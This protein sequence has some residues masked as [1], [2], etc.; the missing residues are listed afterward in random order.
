MDRIII[1]LAIVNC[2]IYFV[3]TLQ[4]CIPWCSKINYVI[5]FVITLQFYIPWCSKI[6]ALIAQCYIPI[7]DGVSCGIDQF[8]SSHFVTILIF[9]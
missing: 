1:I 2:A 6:N 9:Y 7:Q 8:F 5:Y 3:I 4:F